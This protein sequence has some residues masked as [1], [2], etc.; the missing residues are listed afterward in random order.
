MVARRRLPPAAAACLAPVLLVAAACAGGGGDQ[1]AVLPEAR[2]A[3]PALELATPA[4]PPNE[5][6]E[7]APPPEPLA[8]AGVEPEPEL[9]P[10][11][12]TPPPAPPEETPPPEPPEPPAP[13]EGP[14]GVAAAEAVVSALGE[15]QRAVMSS[16]V[17]VYLSIDLLGVGAPAVSV[18]DVPYMLYTSAGGR[19][20]V[21]LDHALAAAFDAAG[22]G[23][24]LAAGGLA[25]SEIVWA[26]ETQHQYINLWDPPEPTDLWLRVESTD[27]GLAS[28]SIPGRVVSALDEFVSLLQ[29]A[30]ASG[31]LL[32]TRAGAP[33][34]VVG[35]ATETYTFVVDLAPL[36]ADWPRFLEMFVFG[37]GAPPPG[38]VLAALP[39]L[40][41]EIGVHVDAEGFVRQAQLDVDLGALMTAMAAAFAA[42][43]DEAPEGEMPEF[44]Y[45]L[46]MRFEVLALNDPSLTITLPPPSQVAD[47]LGDLFADALLGDG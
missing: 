23:E 46:G 19:I 36:S 34:E 44:E 29:M 26:E 10:P 8:S 6:A 35:V 45:L 21:R 1:L 38:E 32:E 41:T 39:A 33:G 17:Q 3:P 5:S 4:A 28:D 40:P 20:Y 25:P 31:A 11:E 15:S 16:R 37:G 24:P 42:F 47:N 22:L 2:Q 12:E 14:L 7:P 27:G 30:A 43:A 13:A 9:A 18:S